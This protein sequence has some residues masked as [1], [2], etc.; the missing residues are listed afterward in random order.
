M[1]IFIQQG[2]VYDYDTCQGCNRQEDLI[3]RGA[4]RKDLPIFLLTAKNGGFMRLCRV[5]LKELKRE[6]NQ[7]I[8]N[9]GEII[10]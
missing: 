4:K 5:C 8:Y 6:F 1:C 3:E 9:T 7:Y 2:T 10:K